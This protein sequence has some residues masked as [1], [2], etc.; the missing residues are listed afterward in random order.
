MGDQLSELMHLPMGR[1]LFDR[2]VN[3][4]LV[5]RSAVSDVLLTDWRSIGDSD[6]LLGAQWPRGHSFYLPIAGRWY[7]PVLMAE[8]IRQAGLLIAHSAYGVPQDTRFL[9]GKL[10]YTVEPAGLAHDGAPA[11]LSLLVT[12]TDVRT[13]RSALRG[14]RIRVHVLRDGR[15][16]GA[17]DGEFTCA[18]PTSYRRLRGDRF[19]ARPSGWLP[20]PAHPPLVGRDR[21]ADVVLAPR[22]EPDSWEIRA[23]VNHPVLFDHPVDHLPGMTLVEAMRQAACLAVGSPAL[24]VTELDCRFTKYV[25]F[26]RPCVVHAEPGTPTRKGT[27]VRVVLRQDGTIAAEGRLT[28][29]VAR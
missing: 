15:Q 29:R 3:R 5:H 14:M 16:L 7:D 23:D 10:G 25:E 27:P 24:L 20:A 28:V 13:L 18:S 12:C 22:G 4:G 19:G 1:V 21:V 6:H 9:L 11:N 17:G 26:D 2:T 8:T